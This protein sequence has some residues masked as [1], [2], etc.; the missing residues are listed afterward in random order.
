M[1]LL[2]LPFFFS[3]QERG[4]KENKNKNNK[5][6]KEQEKNHGRYSL[7]VSVFYYFT[8]R[9]VQDCLSR[10]AADLVAGRG[11]GVFID[12]VGCHVFFYAFLLAPFPI[13]PPLLC[14]GQEFVML[15]FSPTMRLFHLPTAPLD[16]L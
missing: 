8:R 15:A 9:Y 14:D 6:N 1:F 4:N 12:T 7:F 13:S 16:A 2:S 11:P 10:L 5:K 3:F